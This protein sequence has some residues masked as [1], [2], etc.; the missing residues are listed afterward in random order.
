M[1]PPYTLGPARLALGTGDAVEG[2]LLVEN[3]RIK[4]VLTEPGSSDFRLPN[5]STIAPGMI[6][7]HTNGANDVLFNR[8]QGHAVE[9]ASQSYASQGATGFVA[10]IMTGALGIDVAR[11]KRGRRSRAPDGGKPDDRGRALPRHSLR[12]TVPQSEISA[13]APRRLALAGDA[14]ACPSARRIVPRRAHHGHDGAGSRWRRR[15]RA[16]LLR[17][18]HR[19]FCR[20]YGPR[21]T[22]TACSRSHSASGR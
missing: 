21:G 3:G 5:G 10:T 15:R 9:T 22:A 14:R 12:R 2:R 11:C 13:R 17:S 8:D 1:A 16:L 18:G 19:V 4:A 20:T 7:V 6:D